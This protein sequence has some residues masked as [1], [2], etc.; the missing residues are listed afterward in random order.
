MAEKRT[1]AKRQAR[2]IQRKKTGSKALTAP[3]S[4]LTGAQASD[5]ALH[6]YRNASWACR[7]C[8]QSPQQFKTTLAMHFLVLLDQHAR[9]AGLGTLPADVP[10]FQSVP[11]PDLWR[12]QYPV[13]PAQEVHE[14]LA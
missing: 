7:D 10:D 2:Y 3:W 14:V 5:I 12:P 9:S 8:T 13:Y 4:W 11:A 1:S 6:A